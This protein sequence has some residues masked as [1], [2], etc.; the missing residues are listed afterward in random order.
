MNIRKHLVTKPYGVQ[1]QYLFIEKINSWSPYPYV[2][3][4]NISLI[5]ILSCEKRNLKQIHQHGPKFRSGISE[6]VKL[7]RSS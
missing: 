4:L 2:T 3:A 7:D 1:K 5:Y 6:F